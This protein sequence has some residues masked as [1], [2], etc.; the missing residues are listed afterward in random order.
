MFDVNRCN[1]KL[2]WELGWKFG[3]ERIFKTDEIINFCLLMLSK[4][5]D[6]SQNKFDEEEVIQNGP[7]PNLML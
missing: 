1:G 7:S 5:S 6:V 3:V 2:K 4:G